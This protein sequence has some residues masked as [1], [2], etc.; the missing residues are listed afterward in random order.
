VHELGHKLYVGFV[1]DVL[2]VIAVAQA[3]VER[4]GRLFGAAEALLEGIHSHCNL[5]VLNDL[6]PLHERAIAEMRARPEVRE[7]QTAWTIG[8]RQSEEDAVAYALADEPAELN[9]RI[10]AE[11]PNWC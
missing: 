1:L 6:G 8:Q 9:S 10:S 7:F 4:A 3:Q 11:R 2:A 5:L